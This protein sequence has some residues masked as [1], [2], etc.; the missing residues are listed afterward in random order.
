[1]DNERV[2]GYAAEFH[3]DSG[4]R[5]ELSSLWTR[6]EGVSRYDGKTYIGTDGYDVEWS[7]YHR[8][9][10]FHNSSSGCHPP[11][12]SGIYFLSGD[13]EVKE[14]PCQ[15]VDSRDEPPWKSKET[16]V[17]R[18]RN[19]TRRLAKLPKAFNMNNASDLLDWL[20]QNGI[21]S[22]AVYCSI[23]RDWFTG[24]SGYEVCEHVWW[25]DKTADWS[26]PDERCECKDREEC[27]NGE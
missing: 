27:G 9:Y 14:K 15:L 25:C 4:G 22:D 5:L 12:I 13:M 2:I 16:Q 6:T 7:K 8:S 19:R 24:N 10:I 20:Q 21:E 26:T 1:M 3:K 23:C 17:I 11:E 18:R